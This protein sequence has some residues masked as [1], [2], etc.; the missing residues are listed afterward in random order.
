M[1]ILGVLLGGYALICLFVFL[2]FAYLLKVEIWKD[3]K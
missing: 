2:I 3:V 1:P